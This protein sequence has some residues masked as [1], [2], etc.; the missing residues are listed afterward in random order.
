L[1]Y[2]DRGPLVVKLQQALQ[3]HKL[4][5]QNTG[6]VKHDDGIFGRGTENAVKAFQKIIGVDQTGIV[7]NY[8]AQKIG[9]NINPMKTIVLTAGH[10]N[11]DSGAVSKDQKWTEAKI[12]TDLRNRVKTILE[13]YGYTVITDGKGEENLSLSKAVALIPMGE[14]AIELH[15]NAAVSEQANGIEALAKS[16]LKSKCQTLCKSISDDMK[17]KIRGADGGWKS[18]DS[19]QH[20]RLAFCEAGGIILEVF[21]ISNKAELD[22]YINNPDRV[23]KAIAD[24]IKKL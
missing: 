17:Y 2:G 4:L 18:T 22:S 9:I 13:A 12:V 10:N 19:G 20:S 8:F 11:K 1:K 3:A 14:V 23:A 5:P 6:K 16:N 21:F 24:A 15:L 7:G